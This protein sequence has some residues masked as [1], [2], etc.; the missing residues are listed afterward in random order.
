MCYYII[1]RGP[2]GVGKSTIARSL[3]KLLRAKY[4]SMDL[5][6]RKHGLDKAHYKKGIPADNF[7]KANK[8]IL[9]EVKSKLKA[10]KIVIFD[11]CFYHKK[12]IEHIIKSLSVP[13]YI[14]T[15]KAP[16]KVCIARDRKRKKSYGKD[17]ATAVHHL[18]S[19]F[20]H[21][22]VINT[23]KKTSAQTTKKVLLYLPKE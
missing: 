14:F 15:L 7:I 8:T 17:A 20:D 11:G 19:R 2:L 13:H 22:I 10:G 3:A 21:G 23:N 16:L 12:Q 1:I 5:I 6:L 18:V 4:V 9:P